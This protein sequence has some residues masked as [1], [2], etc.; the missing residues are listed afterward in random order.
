[1]RGLEILAVATLALG[2]RHILN[3]VARKDGSP[4]APGS[5]ADMGSG[6]WCSPDVARTDHDA[7]QPAA[8]DGGKRV[9]DRR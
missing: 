9:I 6:G 4:R 7:D 2:A 1:M 5:G 8:A 3:Y